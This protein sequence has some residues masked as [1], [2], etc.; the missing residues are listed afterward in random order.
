MSVELFFRPIHS[1]PPRTGQHPFTGEA[2]ILRPRT[3]HASEEMRAK[4]LLAAMPSASVQGDP[5]EEG[6][7]LTLTGFDSAEAD[8]VYSLMREAN[9]ICSHETTNYCAT[10]AAFAVPLDPEELEL[11]V[12]VVFVRASEELQL[13]EG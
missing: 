12:E 8:L 6:F 11:G 13:A 2:V 7:L 1:G 9:L 5:L 3:M 4:S 10:D